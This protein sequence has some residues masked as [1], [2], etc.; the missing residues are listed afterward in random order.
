MQLFPAAPE[1]NDQIGFDQNAQMFGDTL[2]GHAE[3]SAKLTES[4]AIGL[5]QLIK[6]GAP[7]RIGQGF[8]DVIHSSKIRNQMV[9]YER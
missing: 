8:E 5:V 4:L 2:A 6:Q 7:A 3:M 9:A 1:W